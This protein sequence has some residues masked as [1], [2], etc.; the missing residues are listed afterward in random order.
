MKIA[1][2][3]IEPCHRVSKTQ[4]RTTDAA[5]APATTGGQKGKIPRPSYLIIVPVPHFV[6][7]G[8]SIVPK[9]KRREGITCVDQG[10]QRLLHN[11][12]RL[13][14][15]LCVDPRLFQHDRRSKSQEGLV[16]IQ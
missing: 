10:I 9:F 14:I 4:A 15:P 5:P 8:R 3:G 6:K 13:V 12:N 16:E 2:Q 7:L 11:G 1:A